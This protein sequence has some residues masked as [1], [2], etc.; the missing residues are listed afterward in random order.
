MSNGIEDDSIKE[1]VNTLPDHHKKYEYCLTRKEYRKGKRNTAVKVFT[2]NSESQY[3]MIRNVHATGLQEELL[4]LFSKYGT[5]VQCQAIDNYPKEPFTQVFLLKFQDIQ[6]ARVAKRKTDEMYFFGSMLHVFYAP[7]HETVEETR[8][9]LMGRRIAVVSRLRNLTKEDKGRKPNDL[10]KRTA[11]KQHPSKKVVKP[12]ISTS[13]PNAANEG[14]FSK[15]TF[16]VIHSDNL[17]K[18]K[19]KC[20]PVQPHGQSGVAN[21]FPSIRAVK[22][23]T[24]T[25]VNQ[26]T[27]C[28]PKFTPK[29]GYI[30]PSDTW[31]I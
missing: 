8:Q 29:A 16:S 26:K 4:K 5:V 15:L 14:T 31:R 2:V 19:R 30:P 20:G 7:E 1:S 10:H 3:I 27:T 22:Q 18:A 9:K 24:A 21:K 6:C 25:N 23:H 13:D 17:P 12:N 28:K 11:V